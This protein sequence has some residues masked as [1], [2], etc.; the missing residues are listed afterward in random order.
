VLNW[1]KLV[2]NKN[3][4]IS[5]LSRIKKSFFLMLEMLQ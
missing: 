1:S 2:L 4:Y 3:V 5:L